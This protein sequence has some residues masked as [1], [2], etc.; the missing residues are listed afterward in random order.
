MAIYKE[1]STGEDVKTIQQQL[2]SA[3]FDPGVIDGIYG[4]QT[5]AAVKNFQTAAGITSDSI[6][7]PETASTLSTYKPVTIP[8]AA[9][10]VTQT[11]AQPTSQTVAKPLDLANEYEY[12]TGL[13]AK[14][15]GNVEFAKNKMAE[16]AQQYGEEWTKLAQPAAPAIPEFTPPTDTGYSDPY[17]AKID[18]A[19][20]D[21]EAWKNQPYVFQ[22]ADEMEGLIRETLTRQFNFDPATDKSLQL[23]IKD[24]TRNVMES[25]NERGILNSTITANQ[26]TQGA[27]ELEGT[28]YD[29]AYSRFIDEGN[30]LLSKVDML[31][32]ANDQQYG[33]YMDEGEKYAKSL[34]FLMN[35]NDQQFS[36]YK[37]ARDQRYTAAK[38]K[39]ESDLNKVELKRTA[40][41]DAWDR[42][43][44]LGY[45]DNEAAITLGVAPGTLSK[46]AREA[47]EEY[48]RQMKELEQQH[49]YALAETE[50]QYNKEAKLIKLREEEEK[51][52]TDV[53]KM[54][55][56]EQVKNYYSLR[57][58]YLGGGLGQFANDPYGAYQYLI[59]HKQDQMRFV[60]EQLYNQLV[61]DVSEHLAMNSE[62]APDTTVKYD[63]N[64][65]FTVDDY[66]KHIDS[67]FM[68]DKKGNAITLSQIT[69]E[70]AA[71]IETYINN[72]SNAGLDPNIVQS[73][74]LAYG[75]EIEYEE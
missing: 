23:A 16:Y 62:Y 52:A 30:M 31:M 26:V 41:A 29:K 42:T 18:Q 1:G 68:V 71:K 49:K 38:D 57:D 20:A 40:I 70:I 15:G 9:P 73:L 8:T 6:Y 32:G 51:A 28:F 64:V 13:I 25:M 19:L 10:A 12:L 17:G 72:L 69:P 50:A 2:K 22:Y 65:N 3:G 75:L 43:S 37:D 47:K 74:A 48:E 59:S 33:R 45:V 46:E 54:G 39:Y 34:D 56:P 7:G 14:G 44:N 4:P 55:T 21:Y 61:K 36:I 53:T 5:A 67:N 27:G 66:K 35:L 60:G 24:M 11:V 58:Q 63:T